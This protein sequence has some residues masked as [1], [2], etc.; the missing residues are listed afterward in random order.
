MNGEPPRFRLLTRGYGVLLKAYS[1][2][3]REAWGRDLMQ[4]FRARCARSLAEGGRAA[5]ARWVARAVLDVVWNAPLER[6]SGG[7]S[8]RG[9]IAGLAAA[10]TDAPAPT[11]L[12][13]GGDSALSR[14]L[15][16]LRFAMRVLRRRPG[17]TATLVLT[18]ALGTGATTALFSIVDAALLRPLPYPD[19]DRLVLVHH[20]GSEFG[21]YG[22]APP[23][24]VDLREGVTGVEGL[25]GFSP[26]WD[27]TLT[28]LGD[29]RRVQ[30]AYVSDGLFEL[31]G[32]EPVA[33][34]SFE[35][36]EHA[37]GGPR[38]VAVGRPFWARHFGA[39]TP[40][41]GQTIELDGETYGVVGIMPPFR[42][43]ITASVVDRDGGT[44]ELW[45]PF[46]ANPYA[47][48]R[49]AP[50]MNVMGRLGEG[51]TVAGVRAELE[52]WARAA[53]GES[54]PAVAATPL[55]EVVTRDARGTVLALFGAAA[56][57]LLIACVNVANLLLARATS[58]GPELAVR[59]SLGAG[60]RRLVGQLLTES[61]VVA[62][63]GCGVGLGAAW[64]LLSVVP[65]GVL[66]V[67]PSA[68]VRMD[69]RVITFAALLSVGSAA[70]FGLAPALQATGAGCRPADGVRTTGGGRRLRGL[71][72]TAEVA[73]AVTLLTGA[74]LLARSFWNLVRVDPGFRAEGLLQVPLV[75]GGDRYATPDAR[76]AF[77]DEL[78]PALRALP[79][80]RE[81]VAVN[82]LPLAGG[83]VLVGVEPEGYVAADG[84]LPWLDRRVA[85]PG[86]FAAMGIPIVEG[87][88]FGPDDVPGSALPAA[89]VNESFV[90]RIWPGSPA[91]GR[92]LRLM[93][94][95]GPGPWLTVVGVVGDV[96][97][98]GLD[99]PA[100][101]EVYVPYAQAPVE[102]MTVVVR[103]GGDPASLLGAARAEVRRLDPG[104]PLE[105][106]APVARV[107]SGS[108]D[109]PR[110]RAL[111]LNGFGALALLLAAVGIYGVMSYSVAQRTR[112]TGVRMAL[113][114][115]SGQVLGQVV[116]EGLL[117]AAGG[118]ALGLA[119]SWAVS[120]LLGRFLFRVEPADPVTFV[121]VAGLLLLVAAIASYVP[122]RRAASVDPV[123]AL[124]GE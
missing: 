32:V 16:D 56:F 17:W 22:F 89:I 13:P 23:Y 14:L 19:P 45:L 25:A 92:R 110:I 98:H 35:A 101:P 107:V 34:R 12:H 103:T 100:E 33:G 31:L 28:G 91:T 106:T 102:S 119:G 96:R 104:I 44:A 79:G 122:A 112:E 20:V 105:R 3:F 117:S 94:Q 37:L 64:W 6:M 48:I 29:A 74:G 41:A 69:G 9:R 7:A 88:E 18:L 124:R 50:V 42:L 99:R 55:R 109:E 60:R 57:L 73:L 36:D 47:A 86:Y 40:L 61:L 51:R 58:R 1:R 66:P 26:T 63:L 65:P 87:R 111:V 95:S 108:V 4:I 49:A 115:R 77:L 62:L 97:H 21:H 116:R 80:A 53:Y 81:V 71:L 84:R 59:R 27:L 123:L 10:T 2:R 38:V 90:R 118:V 54:D 5:L 67:P 120:R 8:G 75:L 93:L 78:L 113:G 83:N 82:R 85:T 76:R 15:P 11:P 30:A 24:L 114:A 121:A 72:L 46:A 43:P 70:L 39:G 52:A 68:E